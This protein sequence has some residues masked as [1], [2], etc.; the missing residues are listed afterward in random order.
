MVS[1]E[2]NT[3]SESA[4][5]NADIAAELRYCMALLDQPKLPDDDYVTVFSEHNTHSESAASNGE[6]RTTVT[7]DPEL[8]F[9]IIESDSNLCPPP[10]Q[11]KASLIP[12]AFSHDTDNF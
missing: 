11:E 5:S 4:I 2:H 8:N 9:D 10:D 3:H 1:S 6:L 12:S 7:Y